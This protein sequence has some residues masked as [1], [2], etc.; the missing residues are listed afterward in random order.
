MT[1]LAISLKE[2]AVV[3]RSLLEG[4]QILLLR[5]GGIVEETGDFALEADTA[6]IF[7]TYAHEDERKGDLQPCF[8]QWL[9]EEEDKKPHDGFLRLESFIHVTDVI[10]VPDRE[11]LLVL[12]PQHIWSPQFIHGRYD[13]EPYKP[14]FA[15]LVRAWALPSAVE[16]LAKKE[17]GGCRSWITLGTPVE[18]AAAVPVLSDEHYERRRVLTKSILQK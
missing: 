9:R 15:L 4:H 7:P 14:I 12:S 1:P 16:V 10:P 13:W 6:L 2:W 18:V 11:R 3:Q 17:Y 5:K 8:Q